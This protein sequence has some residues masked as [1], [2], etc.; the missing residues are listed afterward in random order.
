MTTTPEEF[1]LSKQGV[2]KLLNVS[3]RT[4]QHW[5]DTGL[6]PSVKLGGKR[7]YLRQAVIL[8]LRSVSD[9]STAETTD[10]PR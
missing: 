1:V 3:P 4:V 5:T 6:L 9:L 7:L 2:A 10:G 8:F